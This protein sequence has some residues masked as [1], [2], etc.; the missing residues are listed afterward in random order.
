MGTRG[1][2]REMLTENITGVRQLWGGVRRGGWELWNCR[3]RGSRS[4]EG[5]SVHVQNIQD[6]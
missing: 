3:Q 5:E 2:Q 1:A 4:C 6:D